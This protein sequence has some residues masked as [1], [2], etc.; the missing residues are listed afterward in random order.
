MQLSDGV[1][2]KIGD[3]VSIG[4]KNTMKLCIMK[5]TEH[6]VIIRIHKGVGQ[7]NKNSE[8]SWKSSRSWEQF[9]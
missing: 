3:Q 9:S 6:V 8:P 4:P 1:A 2:G 5:Q 7:K